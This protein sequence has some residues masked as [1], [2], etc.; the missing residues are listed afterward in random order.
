MTRIQNFTETKAINKAMKL[1]WNKG[2]EAVTTEEIL[3]TTGL[4]RNKFDE[5]FGSKDQLYLAA[6][7]YYSF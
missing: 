4:N 7:N 1:F 6:F 2:Y 5:I 3:E